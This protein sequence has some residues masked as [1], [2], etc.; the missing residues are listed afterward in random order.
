MSKLNDDIVV[1]VRRRRP[2]IERRLPAVSVRD[3][4]QSPMAQLGL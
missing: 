4:E 1:R 2:L 3:S